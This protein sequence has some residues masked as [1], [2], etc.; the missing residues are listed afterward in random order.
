MIK[1]TIYL[2]SGAVMS[3]SMRATAT[4]MESNMILKK[5]QGNVFSLATNN[6]AVVLDPY[7]IAGM[8]IE[9]S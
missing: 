7:E 4:N 8:I 1:V 9:K 2:K 6:G 5:K 3:F